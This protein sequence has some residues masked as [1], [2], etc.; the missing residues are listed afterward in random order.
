MPKTGA[1]D[2]YRKDT[3]QQKKVIKIKTPVLFTAQ[4]MEHLR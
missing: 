1:A 3:A 2:V 4:H